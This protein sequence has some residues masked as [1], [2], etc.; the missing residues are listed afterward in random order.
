[1]AAITS[2]TPLSGCSRAR[3][4]CTTATQLAPPI[5][6]RLAIVSRRADRLLGVP[7]PAAVSSGSTRCR[8]VACSSAGAFRQIST[9]PATLNA[10]GHTQLTNQ[11]SLNAL[12]TNSTMMI[13]S[14]RPAAS[15]MP[16]ASDLA[17][18]AMLASP[19]AAGISSHAAT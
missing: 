19:P 1:M 2:T 15:R 10:C 18:A 16:L 8:R 13:I 17:L 7:A 5:S 11:P 3:L 6:S 4:L 12:A 9:N 14:A